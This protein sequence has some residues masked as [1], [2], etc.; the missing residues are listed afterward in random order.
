VLHSFGYI[1]KTGITGLYKFFNEMSS[2]SFQKKKYNK[3]LG[4][5]FDEKITNDMLPGL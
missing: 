4:I 1:P 3:F 2:I 5:V